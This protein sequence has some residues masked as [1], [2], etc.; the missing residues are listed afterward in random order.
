ML[1]LCKER[2]EVSSGGM[3]G[4]LL[5]LR[6]TVFICAPFYYSWRAR[7]EY[8][9]RLFNDLPQACNVN[10]VKRKTEFAIKQT[11]KKDED[12]NST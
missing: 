10:N 7:I 11:D 3:S 6:V 8:N 4:A 2:A 5:S 9:Q 1:G 12:D